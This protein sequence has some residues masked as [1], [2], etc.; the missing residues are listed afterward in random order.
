MIGMLDSRGEVVRRKAFRMRPIDILLEALQSPDADMRVE[1][2]DELGFAAEAA[3]VVVPALLRAVRD[4]D[5]DVRACALGALRRLSPGPEIEIPAY[6]AVLT[7]PAEDMGIRIDA[8]VNL[9]FA[10]EPGVAALLE[11]ARHPDAMTRQLSLAKLGQVFSEQPSARD[12]ILRALIEALNDPDAAARQVARSALGEGYIGK[13][14]E[15]ALRAALRAADSLT[16]AG[17]AVV[18]LELAPEDAGPVA[19]LAAALGDARPEVRRTAARPLEKVNEQHAPLAWEGLLRCLGDEDADVR[20]AAAWAL[21]E[22]ALAPAEQAV[23]ALA[24]SL[25]LDQDWER[26]LDLCKTLSRYGRKAAGAAPALAAILGEFLAH[27]DELQGSA[28]FGCYAEALVEAL[29]RVGPP[30]AEAVPL[31]EK[32]ADSFRAEY[33]LDPDDTDWLELL[34]IIKAALRRIRRKPKQGREPG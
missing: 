27:L 21:R 4:S 5:G 24:R 28:L 33:K 23:P 16:R 31:L 8:A 18:L 22:L 29:G 14:A 19:E 1:A 10:G 20:A 30:A 13:P 12:A 25:G 17:A 32:L 7:D 9:S 11:L 6:R 15:A 34:D 26:R 3:E 2:A